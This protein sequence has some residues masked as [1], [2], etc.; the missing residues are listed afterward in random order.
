MSEE[1][2]ILLEKI[3]EKTEIEENVICPHCNYIHKIHDL[4]FL[5]GNQ[6]LITYWGEGVISELDCDECGESFY[7]KEKVCR[8]F[9]EGKTLKEVRGY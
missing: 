7:V 2:D 4:D 6:N 1:L 8:T 9:K 5:E 3:R